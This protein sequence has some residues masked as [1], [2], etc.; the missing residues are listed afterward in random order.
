[1]HSNLPTLHNTKT[2]K[3]TL[4]VIHFIKPTNIFFKFFYYAVWFGFGSVLDIKNQNHSVFLACGLV[5][6]PNCFKT[7]KTEQFDAILF[8]HVLILVFDSKYPPYLKVPIL[9]IF[10]SFV[11]IFA[12]KLRFIM[13][14]F[15]L[16]K[17]KYLL[18][19]LKNQ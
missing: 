16:K 3:I 19:G 13:F 14:F 2:I 12:S 15:L 5:S 17:T 7:T 6:N 8:V 4:I 1:M 11:H 18:Q 10:S 9:K